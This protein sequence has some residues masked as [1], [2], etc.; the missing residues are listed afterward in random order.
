M[1]KF[2]L[3]WFFLFLIL[4][5]CVFAWE[6]NPDSFSSQG[7]M[8]R[9]TTLTKEIRCVVCQNQSIADSTAP[10]ARDLRKKIYVLMR[11]GQSNKEIKKY[12]VNRYGEFILLR[13]PVNSTTLFLWLFPFLS[14]LFIFFYLFRLTK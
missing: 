8:L 6:E 1:M 9:F 4:C 7:E 12:L 13:P 2:K 5:Q 11:Q 14:V 10:L 3:K